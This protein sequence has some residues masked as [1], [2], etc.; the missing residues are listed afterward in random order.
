MTRAVDVPSLLAA[1]RIPVVRRAGE[2]YWC[3]CPLHGERTPSWFIREKPGDRFHAA[4]HCYG[5]KWSGW[6]VQLVQKL[7]NLPTQAEA[8]E[9]LR[10]MPAV[11]Q[12]LPRRVQ[13]VSVPTVRALAVP[14]EVEFAAWPSRYADYLRERR[15]IPDD[16]RD[17]WGLGFV[18]RDSESELAD[19]VWIPARDAGGRLLSYTA[20]AIGA[21]RRRYREPRREEG[22]SSSAVFGELLWP[23]LPKDLVVVTEG[24]FNALAVERCSPRPVA[25]AALMGSSLDTLQVIKLTG[26]KR[27]V[28]ATDPDKAGEQAARQLRA[29]LAR[30]TSVSQMPLP[31]GQDC[32]SLPPG[33]LRA[34]LASALA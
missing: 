2:V 18:P 13:V 26:F 7:L 33:E 1:L 9:W 31:P 15:N 19:R 8:Q 14:D 21:A 32:D 5:C 25:F 22:P 4:A 6:P 16:Q 34:L 28:L 3:C 12:P 20:R 11:E 29:A 27:V 23:A 24:A 10:T 30:Y 17:R